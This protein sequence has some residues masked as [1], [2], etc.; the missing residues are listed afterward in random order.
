MSIFTAIAGSVRPGTSV[1]PIAFVQQKVGTTAAGNGGLTVTADAPFTAGNTVIV[2]ISFVNPADFAVGFNPAFADG[3]AGNLNGSSG[4]LG[5]GVQTVFYYR[6]GMSGNGESAVTFTLD[7]A[8]RAS[9]S[10]SE[11]SGIPDAAPE[12]ESANSGSSA[13]L[14]V[15][16]A[17]LD[18]T[19]ANNLVVGIGAYVSATDTYSSGPSNGFTR[20]TQTGGASIRQECAYKIRTADGAAITSVTTLSGSVAWASCA[21]AFGGN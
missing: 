11:W 14:G 7:S 4:S 20:L 17:T 3:E 21:I 15:V 2:A 9:M 1:V 16:P 12:D 13:A 10:I 18:P 5:T 6:T 8:V 19:S